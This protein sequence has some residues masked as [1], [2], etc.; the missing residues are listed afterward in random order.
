MVEKGAELINLLTD[1]APTDG[2]YRNTEDILMRIL[3]LNRIRKVKI[4]T[5][6]I[7]KGHNAELLQ[8]LAKQNN[9]FYKNLT[10][11]GG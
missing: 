6:G 9:G 7:G 1:G 3:E 10:Q 2:K 5:F 11:A 4:N 8:E